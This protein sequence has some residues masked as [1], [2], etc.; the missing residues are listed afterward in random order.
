MFC[1]IPNKSAH[2]EGLLVRRISTL[3]GFQSWLVYQ[4]DQQLVDHDET[5]TRISNANAEITLNQTRASV[6]KR[7]HKKVKERRQD[8]VCSR[9][10]K[11]KQIDRPGQQNVCT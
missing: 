5:A 2:R 6:K 4:S 3:H 8:F 1:S 10:E 9:L 7:A 11:R